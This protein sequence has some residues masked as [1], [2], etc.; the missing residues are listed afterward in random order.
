MEILYKSHYC[1]KLN[2]VFGLVVDHYV[3][4]TWRQFKH[5]PLFEGFAASSDFS[6]AYASVLIPTKNGALHSENNKTKMMTCASHLKDS[7]NLRQ[8]GIEVVRSV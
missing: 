2:Q 6:S 8:I 3:H 7:S 5:N 4:G 1:S